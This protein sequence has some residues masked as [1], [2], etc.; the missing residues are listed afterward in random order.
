MSEA[1]DKGRSTEKE[2]AK[3]LQ[4]K[5]GVRVERD[6]RSGA[7]E[8]NKADISD[9]FDELPIHIEVKDQDNIKVKEWMRQTIEAASVGQIPTL[10]FRMDEGLIAAMP[11]GSLVDLLLEVA[12]TRAEIDDLRKPLPA[13]VSPP[14]VSPPPLPDEIIVAY[15][16]AKELL[17]IESEL[18]KIEEAKIEQG[19]PQCYNGHLA[20][21]FGYCLQP[22]CKF[23]RG[24]KKPKEKKK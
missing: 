24:Y 8:V 14:P 12:D 10:V 13:P 15:T 19:K 23:S 20:D 3:I 5:L 17:N 16:V 11:F 2:V 4:K 7:G 18:E 6:R 9:W 22:G 21:R 1:F